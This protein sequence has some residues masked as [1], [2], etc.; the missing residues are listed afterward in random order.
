M[1]SFD[2][3]AYGPVFAALLRAAPLSPLGPGRPDAA[4]RPQLEALTG[5]DAF[6]PR[7][8]VDHG[9]AD[10][11]RAGMW[12]LFDFLDEAHR[13]SQ[14]LHAPEGSYWHAI[15][16]RRE[17]DASNAAYWFRRV[18]DHPIFETLA[19]DA[20]DLG[21]PGS[22]KWDPFEFIDQCERRRGTGAAE[23]KLLREVQRRE[24]EL[25][26]DWCFQRAA[27]KE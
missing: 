22:G 15:L 2:A 10:A 12:L 5:D 19:K 24:W 4:R 17:P 21:Y 13:I 27:D 7:R 8:V 26:F 20:K 23:E 25:L 6:R 11:C 18:G 3:A 16:H 9:M 1:D 14:E